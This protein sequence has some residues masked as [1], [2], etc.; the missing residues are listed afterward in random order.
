MT[1][2][3][4]T[5]RRRFL[6]KVG[7][8][9]KKHT[10]NNI[11]KR[12]ELGPIKNIGGRVPTFSNFSDTFVFLWKDQCPGKRTLVWIKG[13]YN[14]KSI[15]NV[16]IN[17]SRTGSCAPC[18]SQPSIGE[19]TL[20]SEFGHFEAPFYYPYRLYAHNELLNN[21][22]DTIWKCFVLKHLAGIIID[23]EMVFLP[24][25]SFVRPFWEHT[26]KAGT[27]FPVNR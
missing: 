15:L 19:N 5:Q 6:L 8:Q 18:I 26:I 16:C 11:V 25:K 10:T 17:T 13:Q 7:G 23:H 4:H 24:E 1:W 9:R 21:V 3:G 14:Y 27:L 22:L 12:F 2:E 20:S